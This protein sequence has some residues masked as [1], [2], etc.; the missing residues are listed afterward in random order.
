MDYTTLSIDESNIVSDGGRQHKSF[1]VKIKTTA[2][3]SVSTRVC[4]LQIL[5]LEK[6]H[7]LELNGHVERRLLIL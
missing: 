5:A 4:N 1:Y 3:E 6:N 2:T 7:F